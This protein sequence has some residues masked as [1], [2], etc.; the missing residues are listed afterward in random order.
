MIRQSS[1]RLDVNPIF[2]ADIEAFSQRRKNAGLSSRQTADKPLNVQ[3]DTFLTFLTGVMLGL[4][5]SI[6]AI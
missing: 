6:R 2:S 3:F 4:D 5:P 1:S